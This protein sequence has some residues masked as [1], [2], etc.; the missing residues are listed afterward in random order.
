M[1]ICF[2]SVALLYDRMTVRQKFQPFVY[3]PTTWS[4]ALQTWLQCCELDWMKDEQIVESFIALSYDGTM[5]RRY[6]GN[7]A[8][9]NV[10]YNQV[11]FIINLSNLHRSGDLAFPSTYAATGVATEMVPL[12]SKVREQLHWNQPILHLKSKTLFRW[13]CGRSRF[14]LKSTWFRADTLENSPVPCINCGIKK[15]FRIKSWLLPETRIKNCIS[16]G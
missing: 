1:Y 13:R 8:N 5:V 14:L 16:I 12:Q 6:N 11:E 3:F 15:Y 9:N 2:L 4:T 10:F 7:K